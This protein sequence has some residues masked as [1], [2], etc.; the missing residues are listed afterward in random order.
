M[1]SRTIKTIHE[2]PEVSDWGGSLPLK[3]PGHL[4]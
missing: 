2:F 3:P 1:L 4:L